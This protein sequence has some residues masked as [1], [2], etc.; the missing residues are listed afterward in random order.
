MTPGVA[1]PTSASVAPAPASP[2][3][4]PAKAATACCIAIPSAA[5]DIFG[6]TDA[7]FRELRRTELSPLAIGRLHGRLPGEVQAMSIDVLLDR[8]DA[9]IRSG[10]MSA[11]QG[12]IL[13][14][15]V[16]AP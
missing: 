15:R 5:P 7:R 10:S 1:G 6:V 3:A 13:L 11:G 2:R 8:I 16:G 4:A 12:E 14:R 9:G